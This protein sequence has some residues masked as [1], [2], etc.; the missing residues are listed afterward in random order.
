MRGLEGKV[1]GD[2][3]KGGEVD[4][5]IVFFGLYLIFLEILF[6]CSS[7][8]IL[9]LRSCQIVCWKS[10]RMVFWVEC[11]SFF[12]CSLIERKFLMEDRLSAKLK[13]LVLLLRWSMRSS[14][15]MYIGKFFLMME[16]ERLRNLSEGV[17]YF[18]QVR[19]WVMFSGEILH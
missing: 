5:L 4:D 19:M 14:L 7:E 8:I 18:W 16:R 3:I 17:E 2:L 1:L 6:C 13:I 11:R 9:E 10:F 12:E 15:F